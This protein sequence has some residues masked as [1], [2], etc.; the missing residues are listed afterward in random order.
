MET[1]DTVSKSQSRSLF[2]A[3]DLSD[4]ASKG[5]LI[6]AT[7]YGIFSLIFPQELV[8]MFYLIANITIGA[9]MMKVRGQWV[10]VR[11]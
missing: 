5:I 7:S 10:L 9:Y 11:I 3:A 2:A 6:A 4:D 1:T 8:I